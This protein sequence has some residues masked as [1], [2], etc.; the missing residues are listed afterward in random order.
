M[1]E[2]AAAPAALARPRYLG[3]V[4]AALVMVGLVAALT[5]FWPPGFDYT[6]FYTVSREWL[7]G[8]TNLF[9]SASPLFYSPPWSLV[10]FVPLSLLPFALGQALLNVASLGGMLFAAHAVRGGGRLP[11]WALV[12]A[13]ANLAVLNLILVGNVDALALA[14]IGLAWLGLRRQRPWLLGAG[15]W[16]MS[17]KS[18]NV[19]PIAM[20]FLWA[21][22]RWPL[23]SWIKS[24][25]PLGLSLVVS[26]A[27][28]PSWPVRY[29]QLVHH[30][31]LAGYTLVA[32][33]W[34]ATAALRIPA[35][36]PALMGLAAAA[37]CLALLMWRG[38]TWATASLVLATTLSFTPYA[39]GIH[40][41]LLI[42]AFLFVARRWVLGVVAYLLTWTPLLRLVWGFGISWLDALYPLCLLAF[43]WFSIWRDPP[44]QLAEAA[45]P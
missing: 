30:D 24:L 8:K 1:S 28:D 4:L 15:W 14:G 31:S 19:L 36:V 16:F 27:L 35:I 2:P 32:T 44:A 39:S 23:S 12:L 18:V 10:L 38:L 20:A 42:P 13:L 25:A 22:R 33:I 45:V 17:L 21:I 26:L 9:D 5:R 6:I 43:V 3:H 34:R 41:V 40:L 7:A 11:P 29:Y 37:A